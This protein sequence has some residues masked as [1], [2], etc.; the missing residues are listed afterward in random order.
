M[1][2]KIRNAEKNVKSKKMQLT[3]RGFPTMILA[4]MHICDLRFQYHQNIPSIMSILLS[5]GYFGHM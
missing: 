4:T 5:I 3:N 2:D 1:K